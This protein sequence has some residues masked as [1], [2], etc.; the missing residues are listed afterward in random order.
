[1]YD[2][3]ASDVDLLDDSQAAKLKRVHPSGVFE[4]R[5]KSEPARPYRLRMHY[6]DVTHDIFDPYQFPRTFQL[7]IYICSAKA[8]CARAIACS[9]RMPSRSMA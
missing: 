3:H 4:W 9:V 6:G 8:S 7:R 1:V 2:P 5:G